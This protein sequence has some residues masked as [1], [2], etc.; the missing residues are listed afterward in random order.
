LYAV[1]TNQG[2]AT[3]QASTDWG[4]TWKKDGELTSGG[5]R[6]Y[7][8]PGS[9]PGSRTLYVI[10]PKGVS[11]KE[12]GKWRY[13]KQVE[14]SFA[15]VSAGFPSGGGK[16]VVYG[17]S[18]SGLFVS[19]DGGAT[20]TRSALPGEGGVYPAVAASLRHGESAYVSYGRL[21]VGGGT[22][23]GVA[24]TSDRGATWRLVWKESR[25]P[26]ANIHD[27]WVTERF[28][29]GWGE[30][31]LS[32]GVSPDNPEECL[33]TDYGRTLLTVDGGANWRA[34][35]S[36]KQPDGGYS[37]TGLDVTTCYGVHFDPFDPGRIFISYTDIGLFR[38]ENGG[39][40]WIGSTSGVP[41]SW[42]NT[43]YWIVFDPEVKGRVWGVMSGI[44]DLPRPK[45]WRGRG[46]ANYNGGVCVSDDGGIT[47][48]VSTEGMPQTAATHI[49]LDPRSPAASRT[50][51]VA[52]Y[53]RGVFKS[54]DGG[55]RW[56]LKN[57]GIEGTEPF[58]W[59]LSQDPKGT[60]YLV[61]ARRSDDG[62]IGDAMDGALY[63]STDGA[64]TWQKMRLPEGTNGPNGLTIDPARADRLYLSVWGRSNRGQDTGGGI[65]LSD[66]GGGG[67]R[68]VLS[69]DQHIYDVTTDPRDPKTLYACG[70]E[71]SAWRSTDRGETWQRIR[72]YNFKWGH[73]VIPDPADSKLVYITTFGGSVWHGPAAGDPASPEDIATPVMSLR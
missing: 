56:A 39:K 54:V 55:K 45:M 60:L 49:L 10:G 32:L 30:N 61:V 33:G 44:H 18:R 62:R 47:W 41:D 19:V 43:T 2:T 73:R 66:D 3:L 35:Y 13:E 9:A 5:M 53:G 40:S 16:P 7:V 1:F 8:D 68:R 38:S 14:D 57:T 11:V 52:A 71:S 21:G 58:A 69:K 67:W 4:R 59:R 22:W 70:F 23:F 63:R 20:W 27:A 37:T 28:G 17:V 72:G 26:A 65:Y 6:V 24:R 46:V 29:P 36:S 50:L 31:P 25:E 48:K 64:E 15:D 34:L 12:G 42:V 51:Y